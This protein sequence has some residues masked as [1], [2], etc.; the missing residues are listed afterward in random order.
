MGS[1]VV[2]RGAQ[3]RASGA[4]RSG[5]LGV[6]IQED[7]KRTASAFDADVAVVEAR[8][9]DPAEDGVMNVELMACGFVLHHLHILAV[10]VVYV[11]LGVSNDGIA[12][13]LQKEFVERCDMVQA[14]YSK[15]NETPP[16]CPL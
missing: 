8:C 16:R 15:L 12:I 13:T 7:V 4:D 2:P 3:K 9:P 6:S 11:D 5:H 14:A 10:P 1:K